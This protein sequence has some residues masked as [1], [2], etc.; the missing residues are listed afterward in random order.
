MYCIWPR[1]KQLHIYYQTPRYVQDVLAMTLSWKLTA[2]I[3]LHV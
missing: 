3:A 2:E 1:I